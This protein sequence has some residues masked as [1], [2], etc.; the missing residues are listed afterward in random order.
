MRRSAVGCSSDGEQGQVFVLVAMFESGFIIVVSR[1]PGTA[2]GCSRTERWDWDHSVVASSSGSASRRVPSSQRALLHY[3]AGIWIEN[4][5]S[6]AG[7]G[8]IEHA[9]NGVRFK[10]ER[11]RIPQSPEFP[12]IFDEP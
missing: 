11:L 8:E 12:I 5:L 9:G 1:P 7:P 6:R 4:E 10:V 2:P 3:L